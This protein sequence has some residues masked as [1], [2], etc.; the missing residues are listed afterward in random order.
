MLEERLAQ[1]Q[2]HIEN[3]VAGY[4]SDPLRTNFRWEVKSE[5]KISVK[6]MGIGLVLGLGLLLLIKLNVFNYGDK[7][8]LIILLGFVP[9]SI[10]L[11]GCIVKISFKY[12]QEKSWSNDVVCDEDIVRLCE[13]QDLKPL[14]KDEVEHGYILTYTSLLEEL[15]DYLTRIVVWNAKIQRDELMSKIDKNT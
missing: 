1:A 15:P 7:N 6:S 11:I 9:L 12:F 4:R 3:V 5:H 2:R 13:N 14:I 10:L 8:T